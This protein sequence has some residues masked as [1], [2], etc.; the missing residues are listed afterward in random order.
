M[1]WLFDK[2]QT[3]TGGHRVPRRDERLND[4]D[5]MSVRTNRDPVSGFRLYGKDDKHT[6]N[7]YTVGAMIGATIGGVRVTLGDAAGRL[8]EYF[9][10]ESNRK[11]QIGILN[12]NV[13]SLRRNGLRKTRAV[14][15]SGM[16]PT[17]WNLR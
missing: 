2:L 4:V 13:W 6:G 11:E 17:R 9:K 5:V 3:V 8:D 12:Q 15:F 1:G 10:D 14:F 7:H 16:R